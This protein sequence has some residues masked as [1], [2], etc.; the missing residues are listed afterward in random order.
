M[1]KYI[2]E[3]LHKI[4]DRRYV[5]YRTIYHFVKFTKKDILEK[6]AGETKIKNGS[7]FVYTR[8]ICPKARGNHKSYSKYAWVK[9]MDIFYYD[10]IYNKKRNAILT[11]GGKK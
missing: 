4:E 2:G 8:I 10:S 3:Y 7:S 9:D 11:R 5:K 1:K 6:H